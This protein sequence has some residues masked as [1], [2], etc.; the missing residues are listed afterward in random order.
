MMPDQ[1]SGMAPPAPLGRRLLA[2]LV[3]TVVLVVIDLLLGLAIA[4]E[5]MNSS[6]VS[7]GKQVL[8]AVLVFVLYFAY[9]GAMTAARGQ[10]LGKMA[11]GIRVARLVDGAVPGRAGWVRAAVYAL[12]GLLIVVLIGP[13]FWLL[14][15]LWCTW[16]RP[17]RQCLHDKAAKT[18]VVAAV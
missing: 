3:D 2:R 14:D 8:L 17:Y 1:P 18:V 15:S 16:D 7:R 12:P 5:D 9:E 11:L 6:D 4:G 13:L 10:T